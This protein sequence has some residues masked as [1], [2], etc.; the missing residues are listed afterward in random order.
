MRNRRAIKLQ[1]LIVLREILFGIIAA[2][3]CCANSSAP[4]VAGI[5]LPSTASIGSPCSELVLERADVRKKLFSNIYVEA[6]YL[7]DKLQNIRKI[8]A[9][10]GAKRMAMHFLYTE[11]S[12]YRLFEN[13]QEEFLQYL[14][15]DVYKFMLA[16]LRPYINLIGI[17]RRGDVIRLDDL[18]QLGT[19]VWFNNTLLCIINNEDVYRCILKV[20]LAENN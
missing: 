3:L 4:E 8:L 12:A 7:P 19:Q 20:W 16:R 1:A 17:I 14:T 18:P 11:I 15:D 5:M 9:E 2:L 6:L 13:L 10:P